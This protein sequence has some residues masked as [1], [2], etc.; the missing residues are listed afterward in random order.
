MR[1]GPGSASQAI[2]AQYSPHWSARIGRMVAGLMTT[3]VPRR[4]VAVTQVSG[5]A[6]EGPASGCVLRR[7][8]AEGAAVVVRFLERNP[9]KTYLT[10]NACFS[11][12]CRTRIR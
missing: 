7:G 2:S 4:G 6:L 10:S 5:G 3:I 8:V 12:I 1:S 11:R 9:A